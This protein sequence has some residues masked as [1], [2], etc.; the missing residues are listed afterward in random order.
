MSIGS[1][2]YT[3][4]IKSNK[5]KQK[6]TI[7][8]KKKG[9]AGSKV[10]V[11]LYDKFYTKKDSDQSMVYFGKTIYKGMSAKDAQLTTWGYPSRKNNWGTGALQWV[12]ETNNC[13]LYV[14]IKNGK[15]VLIQKLSK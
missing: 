14:Y 3:K 8:L 12:F 7:R 13:T 15:V 1:K 5:K 4:K 11:T 2:R 10:K 9:T 6:I